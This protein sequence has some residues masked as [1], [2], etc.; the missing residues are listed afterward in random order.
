M[1]TQYPW[2]IQSEDVQLNDE[3]VQVDAED[4]IDLN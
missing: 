4:S 2:L 1:F 3:R